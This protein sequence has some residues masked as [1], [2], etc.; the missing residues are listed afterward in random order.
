MS[1]VLKALHRAAPMLLAL[2]VF[3]AACSNPGGALPATVAPTPTPVPSTATP[4]P[5]PEPTESGAPQYTVDDLAGFAPED[6]V[7]QFDYEPTFFRPEAFY[8]FG[9]VPLLTLYADGTVVYVAEGATFDEAQVMMALLD[10]EAVAQLVQA[11]WDLGLDRLESHSDFCGL[12]EG[13]QEVCL[14]DAAYTLL[15]VAQPD[16]QM[17]D[18]RIYANFGGDHAAQAAIEAFLIGYTA[19]EAQVYEPEMAALFVW[20]M[21]EVTDIDVLAWPLAETVSRGFEALGE[22]ELTALPLA[23]ADLKA[24]LAALPRNTGDFYFEHEGQVYGAFLTPW[25]PG[26]DYTTELQEAFPG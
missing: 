20:P 2:A 25:L 4:E 8:S 3:L 9:R 11:V 24:V 23:G 26:L 1:P 10:P 5:S 22:G 18:L 17:R 19:A 21:G 7:L 16:G 6:I 13:G 14:A 15:R 12:A